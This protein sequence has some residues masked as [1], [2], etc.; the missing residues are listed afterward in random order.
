MKKS[1]LI[2]DTAPLY[3]P[4]WGGPKRIWNL[5]S[6]LERGLFDITYVGVNF[7]FEKGL[8]YKYTKIRD[9]F[10][11]ISCAFPPHYYFWNL[12]ENS[13]FKDNSFDLFL[14]LWM[15]TDWQ[16]KYI[17]NSQMADIVIC[18][19]PWSCLCLPKGEKQFFIYDA[20][21]CE[22]PLIKQ[23][24]GKHFLSS[25]VARRVKRIERDACEK[26]DLILACSEK[27]KNDFIELYNILPD[28]IVIIPNG[29]NVKNGT[30]IENNKEESRRKLSISV[31]D[32]VIIFVGAY[33]KPNIEALKFIVAKISPHL[34]AF[35]FLI[36]GSVC[37]ALDRH[38]LTENISLLGRVSEEQLEIAFR[39]SD[40]AINPMFEGS[41]INIKMLDYMSYGL[42][43][44][45][46]ECGARGINTFGKQPMIVSSVEEFSENIKKLSTDA[47]LYQRMSKDGRNLVAEHYDWKSISK[48]LQDIVL[49]R[50]KYK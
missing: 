4:L 33:Y 41:G 7:N 21:N 27:E 40:I 50:L 26:S 46:T 9:N 3:P 25:L 10:R 30:T 36:A 49:E 34:K 18:S 22:Y 20:H 38:L 6:N 31:N 11:E 12:L 48:N 47:V 8:K 42:P 14:Y 2:T 45:T 19:H 29:T 28:K 24:L 13:L 44:V 37:D 17:L 32:R 39:A 43:I 5:Y 35:K 23:I 1:I 15:H 16:F